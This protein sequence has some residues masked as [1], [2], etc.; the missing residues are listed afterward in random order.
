MTPE[1]K[2]VLQMAVKT[3]NENKLYTT[4]AFEAARTRARCWNTR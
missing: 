4:R 2:S 3:V 1:V